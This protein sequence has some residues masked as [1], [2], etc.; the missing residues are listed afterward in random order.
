MASSP[1]PTPLPAHA[2]SPEDVISRLA[3]SPTHGLGPREVASRQKRFGF[4]EFVATK[5]DPLWKR[6]YTSLLENHLILLLLVSA[7]IS[8][9]LGHYEDAISITLVCIFKLRFARN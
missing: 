1:G 4:N 6:A 8:A 5:E 2:F 9:G 7:F 3:T